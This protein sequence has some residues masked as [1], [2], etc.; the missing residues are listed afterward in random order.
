MFYSPVNPARFSPAKTLYNRGKRW[1][2]NGVFA[3]IMMGLAAERSE[4]KTIMID[5]S[6]PA[7]LVRA[8][9]ST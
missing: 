2:D 9:A 6:G 7:P 3:R 1:S 5:V 8:R 4:H